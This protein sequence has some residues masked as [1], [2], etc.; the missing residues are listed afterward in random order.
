MF[1]RCV[2]FRMLTKDEYEGTGEPP[3]KLEV[4]QNGG[5]RPPTAK[6]GDPSLATFMHTLQASCSPPQTPRSQQGPPQPHNRKR[7]VSR[8]SPV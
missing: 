5:S 1:P 8:W 3:K 4:A 7:K 2:L 6:P